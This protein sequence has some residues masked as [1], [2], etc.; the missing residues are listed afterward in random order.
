MTDKLSYTAA[1]LELER[2]VNCNKY[3][4]AGGCDTEGCENCPNNYREHLHVEA[5]E[6]VLD[7][8]RRK[9]EQAVACTRRFNERH[10]ELVEKKAA[11]N[12]RRNLRKNKQSQKYAHNN[13]QSWTAAEIEM[14]MRHEMPDAEIAKKLGRTIIAVRTRRAMV[15]EM[16]NEK[17][18]K[19]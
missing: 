2:Y 16:Q 5:L 4:N 15:K 19:G 3:G 14:V 6:V 7:T 18:V 12:N 11:Q 1:R 10:P 9:R 13:H 17:T 8:L